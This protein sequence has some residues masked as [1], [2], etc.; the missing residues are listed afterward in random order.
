MIPIL[1]SIIVGQGDGITTSKAFSLSLVY[2]LAMAVT[3]TVAGVIVGLSGENIQVWFQ[4]PWVISV[5]AGIFVLLSLAM[6]EFYHTLALQNTLGDMPLL[7][8]YQFL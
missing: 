4:N 6:F 8:I 1:S 2:V 7:E 5:F 3:Y